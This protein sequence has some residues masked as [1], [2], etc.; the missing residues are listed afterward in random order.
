MY[1]FLRSDVGWGSGHA[2]VRPAPPID[3]E[4]DGLGD[5]FEAVVVRTLSTLTRPWKL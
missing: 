3:D 5:D 2:G 1:G 4:G